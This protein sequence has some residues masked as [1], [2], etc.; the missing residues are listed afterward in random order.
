MAI[1]ILKTWFFITTIGAV[2]ISSSAYDTNR[3]IGP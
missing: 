2:G 1:S 3:L